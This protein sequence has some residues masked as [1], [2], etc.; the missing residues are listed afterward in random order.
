[1][2]YSPTEASSAAAAG[3]P[4][5]A[6]AAIAKSVAIICVFIL[7][8][9]VLEMSDGLSHPERPGR[10]NS[11]IAACAVTVVTRQLIFFMAFPPAMFGE[12]LAQRG[13]DRPRDDTRSTQYSRRNKGR[14]AGAKPPHSVV[15]DGLVVEVPEPVRHGPTQR[16]PPAQGQGAVFHF[17]IMP[18][19]FR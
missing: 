19:D 13:V 4:K 9:P 6:T 11:A 18:T 10:Y 5:L 8:S 15:G 1:M 16:A 2:K 14:S 17:S 7:K 12:F 3:M